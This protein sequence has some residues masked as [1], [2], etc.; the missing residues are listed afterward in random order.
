MTGS[1]RAECSLSGCAAPLS[2]LAKE[3]LLVVVVELAVLLA[4]LL[5][6]VELVEDELEELA[7]LE[8][9]ASRHERL[10]ITSHT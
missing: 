7:A 10:R 8:D 3:E 1:P 6:V 5:A 9:I 4:V 2:L